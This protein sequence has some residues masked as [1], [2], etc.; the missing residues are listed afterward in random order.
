MQS[1]GSYTTMWLSH[2]IVQGSQA[3]FGMKEMSKAGLLVL[4]LASGILMGSGGRSKDVDNFPIGIDLK[5]VDRYS[6]EQQQQLLS[7]LQSA[8]V[9][10]I[11]T[12]VVNDSSYKFIG[13]ASSLG[14]KINFTVLIQ[15]RPDAVKRAKVPEAPTM[16]PSYPLSAADPAL[17]ASVFETE[18]S[19]LDS[20][21][22]TLAA[23]EV[24]NE[25]N[26]PGFNGE[27]AIRE[28]GR[29]KNMGLEDLKRDPE[30]QN[31][32]AGYRQYVKVLAAVKEVR[33]RSTLNRH[34]PLLLGGLADSGEEKV[35]ENAHAN[36]VT[37]S[38]TIRY[39]REFGL[40][41]YVDGYGIHTYPW[42]NGPG[43]SGPAA[44]R[45]SRLEKYALEE[46]SESK[47]CWVTEWGFQ[48]KNLTCPSDESER[49]ILVRELMSDFRPYIKQGRLKGLLYFVWSRDAWS[50]EEDPYSVFRCGAL[51]E[52]GRLALDARL[53][54]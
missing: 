20:M 54:R 19:R 10:L 36:A 1:T 5:P 23:L 26:N 27:F 30:G 37:I 38:A 51:T 53:L 4:V 8:G 41:R 3:R 7:D 6:P 32:A 39:L 52:S 31:I 34:T 43:E 29:R 12:W 9:R 28:P 21:G 45:R 48:N 24:G 46:C 35:R 2:S 13:D 17:T 42:K 22:I 25:Q 16:Y 49:S 44:N 14:M 40:D 50:K 18:L 33:D 15:Y 11:R 47:P